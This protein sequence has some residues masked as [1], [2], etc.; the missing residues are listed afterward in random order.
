MRRNYWAFA[1]DDYYPLGGMKDFCGSSDYISGAKKE[2][3]DFRREVR[4]HPSYD[5]PLHNVTWAEVVSVVTGKVVARA[6]AYASKE[7]P[8]ETEFIWEDLIECLSTKH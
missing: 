8:G 4:H 2:V 6:K 5:G 3:E 1:G 7:H